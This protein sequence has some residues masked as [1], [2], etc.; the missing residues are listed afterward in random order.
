MS[1]SQFDLAAALEKLREHDWLHPTVPFNEAG[2]TS[3][4]KNSGDAKYA[5]PN[6][7]IAQCGHLLMNNYQVGAREV[8][9]ILSQSGSAVVTRAIDRYDTVDY[10]DL[11]S[12][13]DDLK[14][15]VQR[16]GLI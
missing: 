12:I 8:A 1:K 16:V 15:Y 4:V 3:S 9:R 6:Y 7:W 5:D 2:S 11:Q 13:D 14:K 10:K